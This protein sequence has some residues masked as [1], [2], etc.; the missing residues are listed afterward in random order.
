VRRFKHIERDFQ[1]RGKPISEAS[2][3]EMEAL[4]QEA[5]EAEEAV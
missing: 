5:K 1:R 3:A 2:L 4:W